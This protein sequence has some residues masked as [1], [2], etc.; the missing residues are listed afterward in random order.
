MTCGG[1]TANTNPN[2]S[3]D[4]PFILKQGRSFGLV[5]T[6]REREDGPTVDLL[7][8]ARTGRAQLRKQAGEVGTPVATFTVAIRNPQ[9]GSDRGRADVTLNAS[10]SAATASP[11]ITPGLYMAD[12]EFAND[13]D[14]GDVL[15]TDVFHIR[16]VPEVTT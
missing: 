10:V 15:A 3:A 16:V 9:T 12:V 4:A 6:A 8:P 14:A 13:G 11:V 7:S 1:E 2:G 5:V